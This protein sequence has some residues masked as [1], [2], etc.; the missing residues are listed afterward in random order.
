MPIAA[1]ALVVT[2]LQLLLA[3]G[4][5]VL[6]MARQRARDPPTRERLGDI[7]ARVTG[8]TILLLIL[9]SLVIALR[10]L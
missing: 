1:L 4:L 9:L 10:D 6:L 8:P 3:L 2:L 5:L 7:A